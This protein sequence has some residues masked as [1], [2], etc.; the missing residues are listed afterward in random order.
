M[1]SA[2]LPAL[3][4]SLLV[5]FAL[6][7]PV[8]VTAAAQGLVAGEVSGHV[9]NAATGAYLEGAEV[10][11][12]GAALRAFTDR[13]GRFTLRET[14]VG[15][16]RVRISYSGLDEKTIELDLVAGTPGRVDVELAESVHRLATFVVTGEREGDAASLARQRAASN[17]VNV[18]AMDSFGNVADGNL[19]NF[20]QR[21]TGVG[22][23]KEAGEIVGIGLR[24]TPSHLNA[25]TIDG[26][27][28]ASANAGSTPLGPNPGNAD[29]AQQIDHIPAELFKEVEVFKAN[30]PDRPANSLGGG[31]NLVT[32]SAFDVKRRVITYR[33]GINLNTYRS[34]FDRHGP[35]A[36]LTFLDTLGAERRFGVSLSASYSR[37]INIR[38]RIQMT[39]GQLEDDRKTLARTLN[40]V[41]ARD[42]IGL[43]GKL[44][45][46]TSGDARFYLSGN[47]Y[48]HTVD[49]DRV[50]WR[51]NDSASGRIADYV[52][53]SRAQ[54]EAGVQPRTTANQTA[55][56][57]PG[58]S[59]TFTEMLN[60]NWANQRAIEK[61]R[62]RGHKIELGGE[63]AWGEAKLTAHASYSPAASNNNFK[64]FTTTLPGIGM[65]IDNSR[66][67]SR[68]VYT[69]TYGP[70]VAAGS[71]FRL[72]TGEWFE[73]PDRT[74]NTIAEFRSDYERPLALAGVRVTGK[75]GIAF[76]TQDYWRFNSWRPRWNY[77]GADGVAGR[78]PA[79]TN[80][81]NLR[82]FVLPAPGY[83][84]FNG[85]Y[86]ERDLLDARA[87]ETLFRGSPQLFAPIGGSVTNFGLPAA[88]NEEVSAAY[89]LGRTRWGNLAVLGGVRVERAEYRGVGRNTDPRNAGVVLAEREADHQELFP[90][91]HLRYEVRR[92]L[93][94]RASYSTSSSRPP[95]SALVPITTVSYN[96]TTGF[97]Q[98]S[99]NNPSLQPNYSRNY[100]V[101]AEY[102]LEPAGVFSVGWFHKDV[103]DFIAQLSDIV[104]E[105]PGN[106]FDGQYAGFDLVT[107]SNLGLATITGVEFNYSQRFR[108]LPRP[109]DGFTLMAN[110][111][112]LSAVGQFNEGWSQLPQFI[113]RSGNVV[114]RYEWLKWAAS[115]T[116][117]YTGPFIRSYN[118]NRAL[119]PQVTADPTTDLNLQFRWRQ[120]ATFFV[121]YLN[122]F[123]HSPDWYSLQPHRVDMSEVYGP[124]LNVGVSGRF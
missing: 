85:R 34:G 74:A 53:V 19:G 100:D 22:V 121:D 114:L 68:P 8:P 21:L 41:T 66:D 59:S 28:W 117:N 9:S 37:S 48:Y 111:T 106:G 118:A 45:Y 13:E 93:L 79:G 55:S 16:Q 91:L 10:E 12:V 24:G 39:H 105:G 102:Y 47:Y 122:V 4:R 49:T 86:P 82:Q 69:Q 124:R 103:R 20:F 72:Y 40:D 97:G 5:C 25:V 15:A 56:I 78:T 87:V 70:S 31:A 63:K 61:R 75:A 77:V 35:T 60:A 52:R 83:G 6:L 14:P 115:V 7:V 50:D 76:R 64:G 17:L 80:D 57:A 88:G 123:N 65:S 71:D 29:R 98:V 92:N 46:R 42:R 44:E 120:G 84:L 54:L 38:D 104:P 30:T 11:M 96:T 116:H 36:A 3:S 101:S 89:A 108:R 51:A 94:L 23:V 1:N 43:G 26:A 90:S 2:L 112:R 107:N 33:A 81:D 62:T 113:S 99:R 95:F 18:V 67:A 27:Q 109:F 32:R 119:V 73:Q 110:Y 58:F